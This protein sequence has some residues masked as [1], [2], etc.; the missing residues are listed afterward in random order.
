MRYKITFSYDGSCFHGFQKQPGKRTIQEEIEKVLSSINNREVKI[1]GAG[2]TDS[3]VNAMGQV[4]HFDFDKNISEYKL[5]GAL[6]SYL[7]EDIYVKEVKIVNDNFHA[8]YMVKS[9]T[10]VY[11]INTGEYNPMKRSQEFQY[12]KKLDV[13]SMK[14]AIKY[15]I[16]E[17][18][19]T[20]FA[21]AQDKRTDKVRE[22]YK[23]YIDVND[24]VISIVFNGKG[25]LKYQV[26]NMV[27]VLIKVGEGKI[28]PE[29][30]LSILE[31][32]DRRFATITASPKGLTLKSIEY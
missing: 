1:T 29:E 11:K 12:C 19:F 18:D 16:G 22:I 5:K 30:L 8:R 23:A 32:K 15:L 28:K 26:R 21:S 24:N 14:K 17:H 2:R 27:G 4:A 6:N 20:S 9:K 3:E 10:Y 13:D 25:F 31:K 7:P